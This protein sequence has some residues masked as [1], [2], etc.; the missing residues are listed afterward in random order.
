MT[1]PRIRRILRRTW[2]GAGVVFMGWMF[3]SFQAH[4]VDPATRE[5]DADVSVTHAGDSW[6]FV[7][8]SGL[9]SGLVLLPGGLVDPEAYFP[10]ARDLAK[11]GHAVVVVE[12]PYRSA[13]TAAAERRVLR[14]ARAAMAEIGGDRPWILSGHSKGAAI[15][16]RLIV[17]AG[18]DFA[19]LVLI[20][21][22]HPKIDL[23]GLSVPVLK[24]GGTK[25]CVAPRERAE[26]LID[27]LPPNTRWEWIEGAN[28][29]QFGW[30]GRQINDCAASISR[31]EQQQAT[32]RLLN[33][34]M[35]AHGSA[36]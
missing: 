31:T 30:Y 12:L 13:P 6:R 32:V 18:D 9:L 20:G 16:T 35:S 29:A 21:T 28:H 2:V 15:A 10:L 19:G 14:R 22:T 34:F 27:S 8:V 23:S 26:S 7:P 24:I 3:W 25:D 17:R 4:G 11:S 1:W 36:S 5:S 33:R